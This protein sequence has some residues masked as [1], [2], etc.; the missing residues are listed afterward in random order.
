MD[1]KDLFKDVI[2]Q[3][4]K[5]KSINRNW[6]EELTGNKNKIGIISKCQT[7]TDYIM[8]LKMARNTRTENGDLQKQIFWKFFE[9]VKEPEVFD[10]KNLDQLL[11]ADALH[12]HL[13]ERIANS[14]P[15]DVKGGKNL[16][17]RILFESADGFFHFFLF[18]AF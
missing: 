11:K 5:I 1:E 6:I 15:S 9:F 7:L 18:F 12:Q 2:N 10:S 14:I 4:N 16:G 8:I 3:E 17:K 13:Y